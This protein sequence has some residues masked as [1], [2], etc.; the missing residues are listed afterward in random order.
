MDTA[1]VCYSIDLTAE[2][3]KRALFFAARI[4]HE[5]VDECDE[6]NRTA[7]AEALAEGCDLYAPGTHAILHDVFDIADDVAG[8]FERAR[9][10]LEAK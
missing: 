10:A 4:C 7:L 2:Q 9:A 1:D 5:Y 3:R 6:V 8:R